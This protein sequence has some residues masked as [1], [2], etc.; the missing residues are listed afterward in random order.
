HR[1]LISIDPLSFAGETSYRRRVLEEQRRTGMADAI[2]TGTATIR[3]RPIVLSVIDFRFLGGSLGCVVGEKLTLALELATRRKLPA[4]V[5]VASG[6]L[7]MQEGLLSLAQA[8]KTA[9]AAEQ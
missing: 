6:G 8:A 7:R 9:A 4:V 2:V 3:G 5:V 1:S